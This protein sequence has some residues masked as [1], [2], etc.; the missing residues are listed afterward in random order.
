[1]NRLQARWTD[2]TVTTFDF[3]TEAEF[4]QQ[5]NIAQLFGAQLRFW[6]LTCQ[7]WTAWA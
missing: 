7:C 1:M 4:D 5:V 2:G 3:D 6:S